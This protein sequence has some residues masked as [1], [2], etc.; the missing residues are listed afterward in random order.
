MNKNLIKLVSVAASAIA[1]C[2]LSACGDDGKIHVKF[3][4]TMGKQKSGVVDRIT[5][6]FN[7]LYPDVVIEADGQGDYTALKDKLEQAIPAGTMPQMAFCYPDHV[8]GY[9]S[10]NAVVNI[11]DYLNDESLQFNADDGLVGDFR[12][13]YWKEGQEYE[14]PGTYSV[15]FAKSTEVMFYNKTMFEK[16]NLEVPTTWDEM[17]ALCQQI[18][19]EVMPLEP[20]LQYPMAYDSDS[21]LFITMCEQNGIPYTTNQ[22]ITKPADHITFNN[23]QAHEMINELVGYYNEGYFATKNT[24]PNSTYSSTLFT[25]GKILMSIGST[26]GTSYQTSENFQVA[27]A[28]CPITKSEGNG[29]KYISQGPSICFFKKGSKE[30]KEYAWKYYKY[31]VRSLNT[32]A[33][34]MDSGYEPVR[35]SA[36]NE[37]VYKEYLRGDTLQAMVSRTT[38]TITDKFY[39]SA[40]FYGSATARDVVGNIFALVAKK[41]KTL[42]AAFADAYNT[43]VSACGN[44]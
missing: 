36:F 1:L 8:A 33:Y 5:E 42:D 11:E 16:Y 44:K 41:Q 21:N 22:N 23:E 7:K 10:S 39:N 43:A 19:E 15:P 4:H 28:K 31:L 35:E 26:G 20:V 14:V 38:A 34:A 18:K 12:Q 17:W 13:S 27:V 3:W 29:D 37:D 2:S 6:Q 9:M 30:Q 25:E 32:A 24:L 40:V